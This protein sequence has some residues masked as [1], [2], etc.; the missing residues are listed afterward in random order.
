MLVFASY[1]LAF[2][3]RAHHHRLQ[4]AWILRDCGCD[5]FCGEG[6]LLDELQALEYAGDSATAVTAPRVLRDGGDGAVL[7][8]LRATVHAP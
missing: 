5:R 1:R 2:V 7:A 8:S 6:A 4:L 3:Q